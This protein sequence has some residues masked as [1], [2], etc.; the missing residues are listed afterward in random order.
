[1]IGCTWNSRKALRKIASENGV[2]GD[3]LAD[4]GAAGYDVADSYLYDN[5]R[6]PE[7]VV[8]VAIAT[9]RED[10]QHRRDQSRLFKGFVERGQRMA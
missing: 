2:M 3:F 5:R 6:L 8:E 9:C 7:T 10:C 4:I 1:M